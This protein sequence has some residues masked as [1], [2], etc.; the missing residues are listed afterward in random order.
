MRTI[1]KIAALIFGFVPWLSVSLAADFPGREPA[2]QENFY[3]AKVL[4]N[5][6]WIVGYYGTILYSGDRG[7]NWRIQP[8]GTTRALFNADFVTEE[9][10]WISGSYG[11]ILQTRDGGRTWRAQQTNTTE[12][13]FGIDF[14]D[15]KTGWAVGSQG[16]IL[17]TRDGGLS[18]TS[19][20]I[21]DVILN[22]VSFISPERGWVVG[23]FG[24]IYHTKDGGKS[25]IKQKSP[26][27]VAF[28]SGES[29]NLFGLIF[30]D[31]R[32]GWAFGLDGVILKTRNG[33]EWHITHPNGAG[34]DH[35][36]SHHLFSAARSDGSLWAVGERGT[37]LFSPVTKDRWKKAE[38]SFP[39]SSL[40]SVD[41]GNDGYG[42]IVGNR[43][44][45][46]RTLDAG[47]QW[48]Q[49]K[50]ASRGAKKG[51]SRLP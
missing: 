28:A 12:H 2:F 36:T 21:G 25:W 29:R 20:S 51:S 8:S 45:I 38:F 19:R 7:A 31:S 37:V 22:R 18:W 40:N 3:G 39:P 10:G 30:P 33:E 26:I 14:I 32:E 5:H 11:S 44:L 46:F 49:V 13:L 1:L 15:E 4:G 43:G 23:E 47:R 42:L 6:A 17:S 35:A 50:M 48:T 16:T 24:V 34:P 9:K 41:F 27:E